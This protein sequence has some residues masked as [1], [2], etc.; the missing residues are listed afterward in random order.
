MLVNN[1][2]VMLLG[3]VELAN[4]QNFRQMVE[5]NLLGLMNL[6]H[7]VSPVMQ[8]QDTDHIVNVS[9]TAGH[10]ARPNSSATMPQSSV[11]TH[12]LKRSVRKFTTEGIRTTLIE[13]G[14]V[15]TELPDHIPD[16]EVKEELE[17]VLFDR[18]TR[19]RPIRPDNTASE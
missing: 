1:A 11:S 18:I 19:E 10:K 13:P 8:D 17:D 14:V 6:S 4:R 5:V 3:P 2:G 12:S 9:S 16:K 15:E 7:V